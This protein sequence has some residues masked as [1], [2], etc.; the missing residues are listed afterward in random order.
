VAANSQFLKS[1]LD[2]GGFID[3]LWKM[4]LYFYRVKEFHDNEG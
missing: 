3:C 4:A 1:D 2:S